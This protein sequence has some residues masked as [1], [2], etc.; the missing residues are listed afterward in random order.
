MIREAVANDSNKAGAF[1]IAW[2]CAQREVF[3]ESHMRINP[4]TPSMT[5]HCPNT[6]F[7][8]EISLEP[9]M[10][11][12]NSLGEPRPLIMGHQNTVQSITPIFLASS[13]DEP[14]PSM[15]IKAL[16]LLTRN[17]VVRLCSE[18]ITLDEFQSSGGQVLLG[19]QIDAKL[20]LKPF[21]HLIM[22]SIILEQY[23]DV[24]PTSM[25]P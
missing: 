17:D 8:I 18:T 25:F 19:Q 4:I 11:Y 9:I 12:Q 13:D 2:E 16:M 22:L 20:P 15:E 7:D 23:P 21:G 3:E 5:F 24:I 6:R 1:V 10:E 14:M